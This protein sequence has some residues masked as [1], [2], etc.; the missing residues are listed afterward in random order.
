MNLEQSASDQLSVL[1]EMKRIDEQNCNK[2]MDA[3]Q[4]CVSKL[5]EFT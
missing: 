1:A 3:G 5:E 2:Q 4:I